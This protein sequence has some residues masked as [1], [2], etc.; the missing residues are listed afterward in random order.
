MVVSDES[1]WKL[2]PFFERY[3]GKLDGAQAFFEG[4]YKAEGDIGLMSLFGK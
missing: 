4:K 1:L 3:A 2:L